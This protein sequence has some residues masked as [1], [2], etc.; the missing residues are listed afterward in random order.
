[1]FLVRTRAVR[2]WLFRS[3]VR[4]GAPNLTPSL[5]DE[6]LKVACFLDFSF[7]ETKFFL[8]YYISDKKSNKVPKNIIKNLTWSDQR[9][10]EKQ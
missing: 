7:I 4:C 10:N 8:G 6:I 1:M 5:Y 9:K 2:R 3:L